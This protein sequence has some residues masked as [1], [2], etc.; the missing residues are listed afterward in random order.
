M[1]L[2][3][4]SP[5]HFDRVS[6]LGVA[7]FCMFPRLAD[8]HCL[9]NCQD[10]F[11]AMQVEADGAPHSIAP[12]SA[13]SKLTTGLCKKPLLPPCWTV[14][15]KQNLDPSPAGFET[16][17]QKDLHKKNI[18]WQ[19]CIPKRKK[20]ELVSLPC[21][22]STHALGSWRPL[23]LNSD[24]VGK[25]EDLPGAPYS[26]GCPKLLLSFKA[27]SLLINLSA[28]L[29]ACIQ[30][31]LSPV[32]TL[33]NSSSIGTRQFYDPSRGR[34]TGGYMQASQ[35]VSQIMFIFH[36]SILTSESSVIRLLTNL[37]TGKATL[38]K[39]RAREVPSVASDIPTETGE[40]GSKRLPSRRTDK[41]IWDPSMI[42]DCPGSDFTIEGKEKAPLPSRT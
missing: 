29:E 31:S 41:A 30:E 16:I 39:L 33:A 2:K 6:L 9:T 14:P 34:C 11:H 36:I 40:E 19:N 3:N 32:F 26:T 27:N 38:W 23:R 10:K 37:T 7:I 25:K 18:V 5:F 28:L 21:P 4:L 42:F 17:E 24:L 1:E 13:A 15:P 20:W 12:R 22:H 8:S 35:S